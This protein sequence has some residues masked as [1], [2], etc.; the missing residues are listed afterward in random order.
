MVQAAT[1]LYLLA[2][3]T[4]AVHLSFSVFALMTGFV[5]KIC[6]LTNMVGNSLNGQFGFGPELFTN[7]KSCHGFAFVKENTGIGHQIFPAAILL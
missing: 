4:G 5:A 3:N 6:V 7:S 2:K 1:V